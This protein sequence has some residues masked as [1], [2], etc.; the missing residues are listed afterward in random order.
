MQRDPT[1]RGVSQ[2][3]YLRPLGF[4]LLFGEIRRDLIQRAQ[5]RLAR[6]LALIQYVGS[7]VLAGQGLGKAHRDEQST[8]VVGIIGQDLLGDLNGFLCHS[9][10]KISS[11]QQRSS[12]TDII[13][14][15]ILLHPLL[16][17][18]KLS[19]GI[20]VFGDGVE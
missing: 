14:L 1:Q 19:L 20:G 6:L 18:F 17:L 7:R 4:P 9:E 11:E 16:Q 13:R 12:L 8:E 10:L 3:L 15:R 5:Q 2:R